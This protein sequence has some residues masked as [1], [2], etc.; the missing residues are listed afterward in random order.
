MVNP[1]AYTSTPVPVFPTPDRTAF[2][3]V[4][5]I[6]PNIAKSFLERYPSEAKIYEAVADSRVPSG[7]SR[8]RCHTS[9]T[10]KRGMGMHI[11]WMTLVSSPCSGTVFPLGTRLISRPRWVW[12]TIVRPQ[13]T[14]PT[15]TNIWPPSCITRLSWG[16]SQSLRSSN[17][18]AQTHS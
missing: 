14:R 10:W 3:S 12:L 16:P 11:C 13:N 18:R 9:L 1:R 8:F 4:T 17:G 5:L 15:L 6:R 7:V 2:C